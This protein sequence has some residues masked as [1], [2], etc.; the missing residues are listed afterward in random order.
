MSIKSRV[1]RLEAIAGE[2]PEEFDLWIYYT[3]APGSS[4]EWVGEECVRVYVGT[5][6]PH[7]FPGA[8]I[9]GIER[10]K[11]YPADSLTRGRAPLID[12]DLVSFVF[13]TLE[14]T[15]PPHMADLV[16][17]ARKVVVLDNSPRK[18]GDEGDEGGVALNDDRR[19]GTRDREGFDSDRP[20]TTLTAS[21]IPMFTEGPTCPSG[22]AQRGSSDET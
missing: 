10:G 11:P 9:Y 6:V 1:A 19:R 7:P 8:H 4:D 22:P 12:V 14:E 18:R 3:N 16:R 17:R 13:K 21:S 2:E 20:V 5:E 15:L